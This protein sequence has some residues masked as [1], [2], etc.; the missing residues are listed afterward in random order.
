MSGTVKKVFS[1]LGVIVACVVVIA[2]VLNILLPNGLNGMINATESMIYQATGIEMDFNGDGS[3]AKS[4]TAIDTG[5][6]ADDVA[7]GAGVEG[8]TGGGGTP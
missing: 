8:F 4:N 2:F 3:G 7:K 6:E 5:S 1:V